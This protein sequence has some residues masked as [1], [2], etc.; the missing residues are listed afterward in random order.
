ML[1]AWLCLDLFHPL[2][3]IGVWD[4]SKVLHDNI[5]YGAWTHT[6]WVLLLHTAVMALFMFSAKRDKI[7]VEVKD[8]R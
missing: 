3:W 8:G 1:V 6:P 2:N 5:V 7:K 4:I